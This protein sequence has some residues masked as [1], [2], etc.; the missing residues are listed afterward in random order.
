M[1]ETDTRKPFPAKGFPIRIFRNDTEPL[2]Q[3]KP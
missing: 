1:L 3:G 2:P